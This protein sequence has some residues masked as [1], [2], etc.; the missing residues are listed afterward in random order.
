MCAQHGD[1]PTAGSVQ[2][3]NTLT[4][5][6]HTSTKLFQITNRVWVHFATSHREEEEED[7]SKSESQGFTLQKNKTPWQVSTLQ[8]IISLDPCPSRKPVGR[9]CPVA[10]T[11]AVNHLGAACI[12]LKKRECKVSEP[13]ARLVVTTPRTGM[14]KMI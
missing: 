7:I 2:Y 11:L 13:H 6:V 5:A 4:H 14:R 12:E 9:P 10:P 1:Q 8:S 3:E